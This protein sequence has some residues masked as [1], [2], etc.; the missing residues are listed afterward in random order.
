MEREREYFIEEGNRL[1]SSSHR[2]K[3]ILIQ[4]N[5]LSPRG[6]VSRGCVTS[7]IREEEVAR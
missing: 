7:W 4:T 6:E 5:V 1:T 3:G 2:E